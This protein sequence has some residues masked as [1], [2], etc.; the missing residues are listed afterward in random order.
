M[1]ILIVCSSGGHLLKAS[2]L[3]EW[4]EKHERLWVT[5]FD[6]FSNSVIAKE[7]KI[8]GFFPEQRNLKNLVKNSFLSL[9]V[10]IQFKP[11]IIFS[12]GAGIAIPFFVFAKILKIK[13]VF[14]ETFILIPRATM[15]GKLLYHFTDLFIVQNRK[16]LKTYPKAKFWGSVL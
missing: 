1:K 3:Y 15:T 13:T 5:K 7:N 16:L 4:W 12:T 11:D 14:M 2:Q 10:I 6:N 8:E 9:K